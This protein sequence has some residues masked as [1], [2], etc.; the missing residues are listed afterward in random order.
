MPWDG[1]EL[2]VARLGFP[3]G[4]LPVLAGTEVV[5][6]GPETSVFQAPSHPTDDRSSMSPTKQDGAISTAVTW[7][8]AASAG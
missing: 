5:A 2:K 6:G 7:S 3:E 4:G 1:T 8:P